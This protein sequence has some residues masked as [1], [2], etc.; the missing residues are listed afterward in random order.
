MF[1]NAPAVPFSSFGYWLNKL[2]TFRRKVTE[3]RQEGDLNF[4]ESV[5]IKNSD[6]TPT[7]NNE[8]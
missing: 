1:F 8:T 5:Q 3:H 2:G 4:F 6:V 7:K